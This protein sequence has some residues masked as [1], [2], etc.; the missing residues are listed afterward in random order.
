MVL[1]RSKGKTSSPKKVNCINVPREYQL[2]SKRSAT[3]E[4]AQND[5]VLTRTKAMHYIIQLTDIF[6]LDKDHETE[7]NRT[8][9][10][11]KEK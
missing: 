9:N 11:S 5:D 4:A 2:E 10:G 1:K 7:I 8:S 3:F 6:R